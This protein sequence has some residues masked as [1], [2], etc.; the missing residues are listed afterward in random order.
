VLAVDV[1]HFLDNFVRVHA[2][3]PLV[4]DVEIVLPGLSPAVMLVRLAASALEI[5]KSIA[6]P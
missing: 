2:A 4:E 3:D 1:K 5:A 6:A